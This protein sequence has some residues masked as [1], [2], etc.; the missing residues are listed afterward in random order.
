MC[1]Y[2]GVKGKK[3]IWII[4]MYTSTHRSRC[5]IENLWFHAAKSQV[6]QSSWRQSR[7]E[8]LLDEREFCYVSR[9]VLVEKYDFRKLSV[10]SIQ[11]FFDMFDNHFQIRGKYRK[12]RIRS[13]RRR[14]IN[15]DGNLNAS[16]SLRLRIALSRS[17][18]K[19]L[20]IFDEFCLRGFSD[21]HSLL[22]TN[23]SQLIFVSFFAPERLEFISRDS[24]SDE[25]IR[26]H[27]RV[28]V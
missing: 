6:L 28:G 26:I 9:E 23:P 1:E 19:Y 21:S 20:F 18:F 3:R 5:E 2:D 22:A 15:T 10:N 14:R 7:R 13:R 24:T 17:K 16:L 11:K 4:F 25:L 27:Q 12:S 8:R